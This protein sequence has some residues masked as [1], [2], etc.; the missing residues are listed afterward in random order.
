MV[1]VWSVASGERPFV[2]D[3]PFNGP[4]TAA[5]WASRDNTRFVVGFAS[6]DIHLFM[7]DEKENVMQSMVACPDLISLL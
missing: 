4:A 7:S 2:V 5:A 3:R 1:A 6:G